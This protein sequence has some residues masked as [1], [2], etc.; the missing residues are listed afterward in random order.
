MLKQT[1]AGISMHI[2][3]FREPNYITIGDA[4]KHGLGAFHVQ[5]GVAWIY[6][7][8]TNQGCIAHINSLEY[9]AQLISIWFD[10]LEGRIKK[11]RIAY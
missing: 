3:V 5:S 11:Q 1:E 2:L 8:T 9:L 6:E 10:F 4:C 7:I